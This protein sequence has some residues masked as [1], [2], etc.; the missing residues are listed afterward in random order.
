MTDGEWVDLLVEVFSAFVTLQLLY[1]TGLVVVP[2]SVVTLWV[3]RRRIVR[4]L[5]T[6]A[7]SP[8]ATDAAARDTESPAPHGGARLTVESSVGPAQETIG[9]RRE[10]RHDLGA[11]ARRHRRN[12]ARLYSFAGLGLALAFAAGHGWPS[13]LR[14]WHAAVLCGAP[15]GLNLLL[16]YGRWRPGPWLVGLLIFALFLFSDDHGDPLAFLTQIV[17]VLA[18]LLHPRLRAMASMALAFFGVVS[19]GTFAAIL[20]T[21]YLYRQSI[22]SDIFADPRTPHLREVLTSATS[23]LEPLAELS[24]FFMDHIVATLGTIA[25]LSVVGLL[26]SLVL[27]GL[28]LFVVARNYGRKRTSA[29]WLVILSSWLVVAMA[30][31][32]PDSWPLSVVTNLVSV[33]VFGIVV[34]L[35]W[36]RLRRDEQPGVRMLL[37]R[38]FTLGGRSDRFVQEFET[39]WRGIGSVQL[40]GGADLALSTLEP[41]E[42]LDFLRGRAGRYFVHSQADVDARIGAL[43]YQRDPD[44][45]FRVNDMYCVDAVWQ[46]AVDRLL[47]SSDCVLMDLRSFNRHRA[48]CVFEIQRLAQSTAPCRVAFLVDKVTDRGFVEESWARA[49]PPASVGESQGGTDLLFVSDEPRAGDVCERVIAALSGAAASPSQLIPAP[50]P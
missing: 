33:A 22:L 17:I 36:R 45:C 4:S 11:E 30:S 26:V 25:A 32:N 1:V 29:Q 3:Y 27:G 14:F 23:F 16:L 19:L 15:V 44:G 2:V 31:S 28:V 5:E 12:L 41:H 34:R 37:L 48:G 21:I 40:I 8:A 47:K 42:L 43:D 10:L 20:T 39:L 9:V 6:S 50:P 35:G 49:T 24:S 38:S 46:Y 13:D 7:I 18:L